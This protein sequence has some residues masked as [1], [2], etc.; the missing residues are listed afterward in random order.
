[1][2]L[3]TI[4]KTLCTKK[5]I[6]KHMPSNCIYHSS[7]TAKYTC[8]NCNVKTCC[9]DC[10]QQHKLDKQC[11]GKREIKYIAKGDLK[12]VVQQDYRFLQQIG[13]SIEYTKHIGKRSSRKRPVKKIT[14]ICASFHI[15]WQPAPLG[16]QAGMQNQTK[17]R[18]ESILWTVKLDNNG[19]N[20]LVHNINGLSSLSD[21]LIALK[22]DTSKTVLV[23]IFQHISNTIHSQKKW[24]NI[25]QQRWQDSFFHSISYGILP[26]EH[27]IIHEYPQMRIKVIQ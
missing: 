25:P 21:I 6:L 24:T 19:I 23:Y 8:P 14:A 13:D 16:L 27:V 12:D 2:S 1:M 11:S 9:V 22:I 26:G 15:N 17:I 4:S 10:I 7:I 18:D 20:A 5:E 3:S